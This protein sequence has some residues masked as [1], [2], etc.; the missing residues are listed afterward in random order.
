MY[1]GSYWELIGDCDEMA[2]MLRTMSQMPELMEERPLE[3]PS[4]PDLPKYVLEPDMLAW[5]KTKATICHAGQW[6][7]TGGELHGTGPARVCACG[8]QAAL[9][10][11]AGSGDKFGCRLLKG[12][13]QAC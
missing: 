6:R 11:L 9:L 3:L 8:A 2:D 7:V 5:V 1:E 4:Q 12:S 10:M 13:I